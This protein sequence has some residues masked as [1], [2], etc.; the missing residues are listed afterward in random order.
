MQDSG[1]V[2]DSARA[3]YEVAGIL[4][5]KLQTLNACEHLSAVELFLSMIS[6]KL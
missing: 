6:T 4:K 3:F 1:F 5:R 2:L